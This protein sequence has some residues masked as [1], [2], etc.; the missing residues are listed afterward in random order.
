[1]NE[2]T[3][4]TID[5][6]ELE[7]ARDRLAD[8]LLAEAIGGETPPDRAAEIVACVEQSANDAKS[9]RLA[10][11][12]RPTAVLVTAFTAAAC[13]V[14]VTGWL[15]VGQPAPRDAAMRSNVTEESDWRQ[16]S[17]SLNDSFKPNSNE[18][19]AS[20]PPAGSM[21][22]VLGDQSSIT[23][24]Y[25][26]IQ[27]PASSAPES[28]AEP[29]A[30]R[31]AGSAV[32]PS[33]GRAAL[34]IQP[35]EAPARG[36]RSGL[37]WGGAGGFGLAQRPAIPLVGQ[38]LP[39]PYYLTEDVQLAPAAPAFTRSRDRYTAIKETGFTK[40]IGVEALSTFSVDVDTASYT[41]VRRF[42]LSEK[43]LPPAGSVRIE[44]LVN[45]FD[46]RYPAPA[47]DAEAPF[48]A[49]I[50]AQACPWKP[51]YRLVRIGIKGREVAADRRPL[52]NLVFLI[53]VSG[54]MNAP[55]KLP[56]VREGLKA[57]TRRLGENDRVAIVVYAGSEGLVLPSTPG[58]ERETVLAA[59]DQ[60]QAGGST[61]GGAG[62]RLAYQLAEQNRIDGGVNRVVL[63]TDGDF[64]VGLTG[65]G[66]LAS[67]VERRAKETGVYLTVL[68]FGRGNLNDAM[69]EAISGRGDGHYAYI[70][71]EREA[72][73]VL[74]RD[75]SGTLVTIAKDV[76]LQVE[77]NPARVAA[78]RLIGYENRR[79]S[80]ADFNN[81]AKDAGEIG[82]GHTVTALYEVI[83]VGA[84]S[85]GGSIDELKYQRESAEGSGQAAEASVAAKPTADSR[86]PTAASDELLTLKIRY[87][88]PEGGA[89]TRLEFPLLE[90][91]ADRRFGGGSVSDDSTWVA[92]VAQ[93]GML[94]SGS[95]HAGEATYADV[96]RQARTAIGE[97]PQGQRAEFLDV[98]RGVM[99]LR[100][101]RE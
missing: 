31:S 48:A 27:R 81:D 85:A 72:R 29:A 71:S 69:L 51:E 10:T 8:R 18:E 6:D 41:N 40:P 42:V 11:R 66:Q 19:S 46:Y 15:T 97:D 20:N 76:K 52:S 43:R 78:Y 44:E 34:G 49:S 100:G 94:L 55:D 58:D 21:P 83:P 62:L 9:S 73:R 70:D 35:S 98:V 67:L 82:A 14:A 101:E 96:L 90:P 95:E 77:F 7:A 59:L 17:S 56:L 23:S 4:P 99:A 47:P 88:A 93:F 5:P 26:S 57:L 80:A 74:S 92:A 39:S 28:R 45:Y 2:T 16:Q 12:R 3:T 54:S 22:G 61:A 13:L 60:L 36:R 25:S 30:Q 24:Q 63:C 68:G 91:P 50:E 38:N 64:N 32:V 53:D 84:E 79:L 87:K 89:S 37:A 75:L 65:T 33:S 1:M 86:Q